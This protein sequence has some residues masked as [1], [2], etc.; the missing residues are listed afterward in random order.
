MDDGG[1]HII[2]IFFSTSLLEYNCST[3]VRQLLPYN[4]VNQPYIYTYP[5]I[6]SLLCPPPTLPITPFQVVT[7][8][9]SAHFFKKFICL[10]YLF[11]LAVLGLCCCERAFSNCGKR[12]LLFIAVRGLLIVVASLAAEHGLQAR[13][14]QQLQHVVSVVVAHGLQSTGSVV[15]TQELSCS[16][17]CGVFPDQGLNPCSLHWQADSQPLHHQGSP[18]AHF[19]IGLF[20]SLL[21]SC[22]N[23]LYILVINPL[24]LRLRRSLLIDEIL[25]E[26]FYQFLF[27]NGLFSP[28]FKKSFYYEKF[29]LIN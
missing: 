28:S 25:L 11:I 20:V 6:P 10:F 14:L 21:L 13:G 19:L 22:M 26:N 27:Q 3:M 4:K 1:C 12:E 16:A 18:S 23:C 9:R 24:S 29:Y 7:K 5:H 8:H 15:V 2:M 17:A